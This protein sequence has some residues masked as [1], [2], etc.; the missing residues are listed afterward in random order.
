[1]KCDRTAAHIPHMEHVILDDGTVVTFDQLTLFDLPPVA[2]R[3]R[4]QPRRNPATGTNSGF[5]QLSFAFLGDVAVEE[6]AA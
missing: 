1:M 2:P 6:T 3:K 4:S 5:E